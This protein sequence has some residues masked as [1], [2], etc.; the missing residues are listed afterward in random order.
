[1]D[2]GNGGDGETGYKL[3]F[4]FLALALPLRSW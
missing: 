1:M 3:F 4:F 2:S